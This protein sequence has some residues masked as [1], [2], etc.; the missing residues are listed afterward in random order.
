MSPASLNGSRGDFSDFTSGL[1]RSG[2]H[3]STMKS[4][5][6][7]D[8]SDRRVRKKKKMR[9]GVRGQ[10]ETPDWIKEVFNFAKKGNLEKLVSSISHLSSL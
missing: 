9:N 4:L 10:G 3:N 8:M 7:S 5:D 1:N 2:Y 6:T